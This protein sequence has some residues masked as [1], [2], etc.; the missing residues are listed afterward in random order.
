MDSLGRFAFAFALYWL[1]TAQVLTLLHELGH[2]AVA[3]TL[4][5]GTV[6]VWSGSPPSRLRIAL[7]RLRFHLRPFG[8]PVGFYG[9]DGEFGCGKAGLSRTRQAAIIAAGP[10]TSLLLAVGCFGLGASLD[11]A[12]GLLETSVALAG[13]GALFQTAVTALPMRYPSSWGAYAGIES[14]G[15]RLRR[16]LTS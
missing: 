16:A 13:F 7:G 4:T 6:D 1:V 11:S 9:C 5:R 2:A 14:D 10:A 15:A 12:A 8:G 3:L